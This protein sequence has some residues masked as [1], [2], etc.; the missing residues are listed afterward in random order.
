MSLV[1]SRELFVAGSFPITVDTV[2][3]RTLMRKE[4]HRHEFFEM[5][6]VEHGTL[7]NRFKSGDVKME[8][9]DVI[10]MKPFVRHLLLDSKAS[11]SVKAYC[12][13]FLTQA[14]DVGVRSLEEVDLSDSPN[15]YFF[16]ALLP[17]NREDVSA[18]HLKVEKSRRQKLEELFDE[19][20]S[21]THDET[22]RGKAMTRRHFLDLLLMLA[23]QQQKDEVVRKTVTVTMATPVSRYK[24]GLRKT[25]NHI[26][27]NYREPLTLSEMA[28]M[29]G[30]SETY[31]CRLFKHETGMTFLD[32]LN[33]L[34]IENACVL[35]RDTTNNALDICYEVGFNDYTHFGRQFKKNT[36]M[37]PAEFRKKRQHVRQIREVS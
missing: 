32:Y 28:A 26:H 6:Y 3:D 19:L 33:S 16:H 30:A 27:D 34:R 2:V 25:L 24:D 29:S 21:S 1:K 17:L 23:E 22:P 10:I 5:L 7:V 36:G 9:G 20:R 37:S 15:R 14:V 13:S 18:V 12:C 35:M 8:V 31:F 11:S 4:L